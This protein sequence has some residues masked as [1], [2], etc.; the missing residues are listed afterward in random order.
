MKP[1]TKSANG[2]SFHFTTF[3]CTVA[4][5][6]KIL[7]EPVCEYNDGSDKV[8]IEW[9][10]ETDDGDVF[11]VYDWKE[12]K[13]L[14]EHELIQWHIGGMS[15]SITEQAKREIKAAISKV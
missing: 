12:Y 3:D 1:T 10:M 2:T 4:I 7:G 15:K 5:L 13:A 8:N 11:T 14:S 6:R 9:E